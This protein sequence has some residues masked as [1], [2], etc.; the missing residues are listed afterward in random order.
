MTLTTGG[1]LGI[2]T[3]GPNYPLDIQTSD[4][5]TTLN[6][7]VNAASTTNDYAEIAFQLW[8]GAGSG[9]NTFGGSGTSRPS[10]VLRALNEN[11][12]TAAGAFVVL[13]SLI[14]NSLFPSFNF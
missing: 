7:K 11:G 13:T 6:L 4:S 10:V 8:S 5:P 2:G 3:T 12:S 1:R 14:M 9:A